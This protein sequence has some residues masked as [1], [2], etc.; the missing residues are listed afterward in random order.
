MNNNKSSKNSNENSSYTDQEL[1]LAGKKADAAAAIPTELIDEL[2]FVGPKEHMR[3]QLEQWK[4]L[5]IDFTMLVGLDSRNSERQ[6]SVIRDLA[7][8]L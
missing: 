1:F 3:D 7:E 4:A 8:M 6:L 5:D 2:A